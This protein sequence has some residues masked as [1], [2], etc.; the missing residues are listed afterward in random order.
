MSQPGDGRIQVSRNFAV[1]VATVIIA[2]AI[3]TAYLLGMVIS[4]NWD[5]ESAAIISPT[6]AVLASEQDEGNAAATPTQ[7]AAPAP[8][9][10][11]KSTY[12]TCLARTWRAL[13]LDAKDTEFKPWEDRTTIKEVWPIIELRHVDYIAEHCR[14]LAPAP[15]A[16]LSGTC[17]PR[18]LQ[19]FYRRHIPE[20]ADSQSHQAIAAQY[21]LT[22]CQPSAER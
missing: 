1:G 12:G 17:I 7:A 2:L 11:S 19:S 20:G 13:S 4:D 8:Q 10:A 5:G 14:H 21:A 9:G 16:S 18:E 15:P 3:A 22:V 6:P